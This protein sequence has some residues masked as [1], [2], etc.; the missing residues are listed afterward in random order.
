MSLE[1]LFCG[2]N[3]ERIELQMERFLTEFQFSWKIDE[4][5]V[6]NP[7][8]TSSIAYF[9]YHLDFFQTKKFARIRSKLKKHETKNFLKISP[10]PIFFFPSL[11]F[12]L[13]KSI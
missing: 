13:G 2:Q 12:S 8:T 10:R 4:A 3:Q 6:E 9:T 1:R 11:S 5:R 7:S